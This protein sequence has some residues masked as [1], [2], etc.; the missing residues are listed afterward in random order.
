MP[1]LTEKIFHPIYDRLFGDS[2]DIQLFIT[3]PVETGNGKLW[4]DTR[5]ENG[6]PCI[7]IF[8]DKPEVQGV[9]I[10]TVI[11]SEY[12]SDKAAVQKALEFGTNSDPI[13]YVTIEHTYR[14]LC[15]EM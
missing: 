13:E 1:Y 11:I 2:T 7:D 14:Q 4:L 12:D 10:E 15:G 8:T 9:P 5:R 6:E 3:V